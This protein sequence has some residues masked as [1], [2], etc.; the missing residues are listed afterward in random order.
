MFTAAEFRQI[1]EHCPE[2]LDALLDN[3]NIDKPDWSA[4]QEF[5]AYAD[6]DEKIIQALCAK[7]KS[8]SIIDGYTKLLT[9]GNIDFNFSETDNELLAKIIS[10]KKILGSSLISKILASKNTKSAPAA[11]PKTRY[12]YSGVQTTIARAD[13]TVGIPLNFELRL[14]ERKL[15]P[16]PAALKN[17]IRDMIC[18]YQY[19]VEKYN[20]IEA[21]EIS[22]KIKNGTYPEIVTLESVQ[23]PQPAAPPFE[24]EELDDAIKSLELINEVVAAID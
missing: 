12:D 17:K 16:I 7:M 14:K 23:P 4:A 13:F 1:R 15:L 5:D 9:L 6:L 2:K 10:N 11:P 3:L 18:E 22:V 21:I 8:E 19:N 24:Q 20:I